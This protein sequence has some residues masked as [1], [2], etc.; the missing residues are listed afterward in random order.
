M[1]GGLVADGTHQHLAHGFR[2]VVHVRDPA[3]R[4]FPAAAAAR[5]PG[6]PAASE[7]GPAPG[8][9]ARPYPTARVERI[10]FRS[11]APARVPLLAGGIGPISDLNRRL[12]M[13]MRGTTP[14]KLGWHGV[15]VVLGVG[16]LL[17][18]LLPAFAQAQ[19]KDRP[20]NSNAEA[21]LRYVE[22]LNDD[23]QRIVADQN[24]AELQMLQAQLGQKLQEL[25]ET[26]LKM[27]EV[28]DKLRLIE[29]GRPAGADAKDL[30][31]TYRLLLH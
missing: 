4:P 21:R 20:D 15:L 30:K 26:E 13:I 11:A 6:P 29:G 10:E 7:T 16:A 12:T 8:A 5:P 24:Q 22:L 28:R 17:L 18:P 9:Y 1:V 31:A 19:D 27:K 2:P 14:R 25:R 23:E 3:T